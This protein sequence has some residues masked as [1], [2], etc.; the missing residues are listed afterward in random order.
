[1][2][3]KSALKKLRN[4][5]TYTVEKFL[6]YTQESLTVHQWISWLFASHF[7]LSSYD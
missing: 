7:V 5:H 2:Y 1:M 4:T 3:H 6:I